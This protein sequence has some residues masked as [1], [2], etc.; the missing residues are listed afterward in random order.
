MSDMQYDSNTYSTVLPDAESRIAALAHKARQTRKNSAT[1]IDW[2][3]RAAPPV[4]MPKRLAASAISQFRH[5]AAFA[6]TNGRPDLC[7]DPTGPSAV[8]DWDA[9]WLTLRSAAKTDADTRKD[10]AAQLSFG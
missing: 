7:R 9:L 8:E 2:G 6:I 10:Y 3:R 1:L 4:W 5:R